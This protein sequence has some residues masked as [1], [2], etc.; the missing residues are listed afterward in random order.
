MR[1][2][3]SGSSG[4]IGGAVARA[5]AEDGHVISRL[6]RPQSKNSA[7]AAVTDDAAGLDVLWDYGWRTI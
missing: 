2:L 3:L 5:M 4:M 1:V 6:V 7:S